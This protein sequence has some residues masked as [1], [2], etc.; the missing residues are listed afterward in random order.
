MK[1]FKFFHG[2]QIRPA[3]ALLALFLLAS[4]VL[5]LPASAETAAGI[6]AGP[7]KVC[8]G[9]GC[10]CMP[11]GQAKS[12]GYVRCS[13][14]GT[15]CFNDSFGRPLY[16]YHAPSSATC[17]AAGCNG[18]DMMSGSGAEN[19]RLV[20]TM[21]TSSAES[22]PCVGD[23]SDACALPGAAT[24]PAVTSADPL[25]SILTFFRS[26]LGMQ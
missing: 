2:L 9:T 1:P 15:P 20:I 18:S 23:G 4:L 14:N 19:I 11:E 17:G 25:G 3:P 8:P 16:C 24:T 6:S 21:Q 5:A 7:A 26:L 13:A 10:T 12:L 22:G